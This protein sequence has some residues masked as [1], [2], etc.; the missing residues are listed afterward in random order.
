MRS[1]SSGDR[2]VVRWCGSGLGGVVIGEGEG[3]GE[4]WWDGV[5]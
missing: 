1:S 5:N 3:G 2:G 4:E